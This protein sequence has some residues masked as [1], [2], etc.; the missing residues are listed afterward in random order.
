MKFSSHLPIFHQNLLIL[1]NLI[2]KTKFLFNVENDAILFHSSQNKLLQWPNR[3][4]YSNN[5]IWLICF[6]TT[7]FLVPGHGVLSFI[8]WPFYGKFGSRTIRRTKQKNLCFVESVSYRPCQK[9]SV[10]INLYKFSYFK[11]IESAFN[12]LNFFNRKW[13]GSSAHTAS[14]YIENRPSCISPFTPNWSYITSSK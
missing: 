6:A 8:A 2:H 9:K 4:V 12:F 14:I 10:Y 5:L 7:R 3:C 11:D 13:W 1:V